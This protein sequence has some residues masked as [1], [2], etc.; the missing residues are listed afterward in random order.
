MNQIATMSSKQIMKIINS[1][2]KFKNGKKVHLNKSIANIFL[3]PSTRTL[4]SYQKAQNNLQME[5]YNVN[6]S[7]SS[8]KK[9]ETLE[10]TLF[11]LEAI[12][13][14]YFVIRSSQEEYWKSFAKKHSIINAG[15]GRKN[16]PSQA[17]LDAMTIY[18]HF[19]TLENL[20]ILVVGD[21]KHSRV[22][23]SNKELLKKFNSTVDYIGPKGISDKQLELS[24]II[25]EYD[26]VMFLRIQH[27][28][29]ESKKNFELYN[30]QYGLNDDTVK[31]MKEGSIFMHPGPVNRDVEITSN[32]L[33]D[34]PK[35]KI[36][37][38]AKNGVFVRMAILEEICKNI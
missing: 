35:N 2:I 24:S 15:D 20:K 3:E 33:Y 19:G 8:L 10:D 12:G 25:S 9:G 30:N 11:N 27:E 38:Q 26:V 1:A 7:N 36:L 5:T 13:I 29:H 34:H 37:V 18:E 6:I 31:K 21:I 17:L 14:N 28:R 4:I 16:H 32:L 23:H 22:F